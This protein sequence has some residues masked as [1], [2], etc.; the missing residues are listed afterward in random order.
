MEFT[1][2]VVSTLETGDATFVRAFRSEPEATEWACEYIRENYA[3]DKEVADDVLSLPNG[4]DFLTAFT[5][6]EGMSEWFFVIE[7]TEG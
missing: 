3:A 7:M 4:E 5:E 2:A 1:H 6:Y